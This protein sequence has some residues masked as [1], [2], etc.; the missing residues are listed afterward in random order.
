MAKGLVVVFSSK[1][2]SR[3]Y[4]HFLILIDKNEYK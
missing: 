4:M 2:Q 3:S 1:Y